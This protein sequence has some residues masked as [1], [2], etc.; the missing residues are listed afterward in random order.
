MTTSRLLL[1]SASVLGLLVSV[2]RPARAE[3]DAA[4][5]VTATL[6]ALD[7]ALA[8]KDESAANAAIK[9]LPGLYKAAADKA[10]Q[11]SIATKLGK[12]VKQKAVPNV[13]K[14]ALDALV[15]TDD[16]AIA[17]K[18]LSGVYPDN[19]AEDPERFNVEIVKAIGAL[20]P[21]EAIDKLLETFRK[22]K[23][24]DLAA[25]AVSALGNYHK[26][27]KREAILE[28]LIKTGKLLKPAQSKTQSISAEAQAKWGA[29]GPPLGHALDQLTGLSVGDPV[30]W[31][32]KYEES[33]KNLKA[34][35]KE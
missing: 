30:D 15:E 34:L 32:K 14:N 27:K 5:D 19:D 2:P 3:G 4:A 17:W 21:E 33:K 23:Q 31:F 6:T 16:G 1:V 24:T 25:A 8:A 29:L 26:S 13:R 22:A 12:A 28:D 7:T 10:V 18:G 20:H 35:F 9:K 11:S